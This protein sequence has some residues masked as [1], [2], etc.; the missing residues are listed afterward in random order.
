MPTG[1]D[2]RDVASALYLGLGLVRRR[3]RQ[4]PVPGGLTLP[5]SSALARIDRAGST[6]PGALAKMEQIS[7]QAMG[8]TLAGLEAT[9]LIS[10]RADPDDGRRVIYSLTGAGRRA[11]RDKRSA[12]TRRLAKALADAFTEPELQTLAAAAPLIERLGHR[13]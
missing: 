12:R 13:I 3:L 6:T 8:T 4:V 2:V 11:V 7:P 5:E 1:V 9:G 10:R